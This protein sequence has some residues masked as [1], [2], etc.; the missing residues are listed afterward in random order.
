MSARRIVWSLSFV[1]VF[2]FGVATAQA[3]M[4][5]DGVA[6][7][8]NGTTQGQTQTGTERWQYM[9]VT[10]GTNT[11]YSLLTWDAGEGLWWNPTNQA[12][13]ISTP[14]ALLANPG[15]NSKAAVAAWLSPI[16]G[17]V[18]VSFK[19]TD[20]HSPG[21]GNGQTYALFQTG[22]LTPLTSGTNAAG[23]NTGTLSVSGVS[24][25]TGDLLYFQIGPKDGNYTADW[26]QFDTLTVTQA[27]PEPSTIVLL[28]SGVLG[29]LA[30]AWR[31]RR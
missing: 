17:T 19:I 15:K 21:S 22:G 18:D 12:F 1:M 30:Y 3:T 4:T 25:A 11:G 31:R 23:G 20:T 28:A 24:V 27:V 9:E 29:L 2:V 16:T 26:S 6:S 5:W 8:Y 10:E 13:I 14:G 7:G